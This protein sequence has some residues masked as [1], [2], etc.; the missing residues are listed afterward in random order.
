MNSPL[1]LVR[2]RKRLIRRRLHHHLGIGATLVIA[3]AIFSSCASKP[4]EGVLELR[5]SREAIREAKSWESDVTGQLPSGQWVIVMM[6]KMECPA[7]EDRIGIVHEENNR[8]VHEIWYDGD[9]YDLTNRG[10]WTSLPHGTKPVTDC[11]LGPSLVWDGGLYSDLDSVEKTGEVRHGQAPPPEGGVDCTWW[12]VAP[13][14]NGAAHYS[15]CVSNDGEHLP[16]RVRSHEN[17]HNYVYTFQG[18]NSTTVALPKGLPASA[19]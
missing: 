10:T 14:K 3:I 5:R 7:R 12:D 13:E 16:M 18:W 6:T 15:V 9:Y 1:G 11:G 17:T 19:N 2:K 4:S 8:T